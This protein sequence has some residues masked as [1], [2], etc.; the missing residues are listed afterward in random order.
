MK[1]VLKDKIQETSDVITFIFEPDE[2]VEF[3]AGQFL[4]YV[5]H[6]DKTDDRGSDRWFTISAA[7]FERVV[8]ITTRF[9]AE[10]SSTFKEALKGLKVGDDIEATEVDGDFI[11]D[12]STNSGPLVFIAGGI[13]VTPY[14]SILLQLDHDNKPL[15]INLL[16]ANK[17]PDNVPF[18]KEFDQLAEKHPEFKINYIFD[19]EKINK[20]SIKKYVPDLNKP[21]FYVSGPEPMVDAISETL[22]NMGVPEDHLKGDWFPGY[23]AE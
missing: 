8:R 5:L 16:Y 12:P 7:P 6:H 10:R 4:H 15:N 14:R 2:Q 11:V 17:S 23:P 18:K 3:K 22:K 13:G 21:I 19:P 20:E 9:N 1:L